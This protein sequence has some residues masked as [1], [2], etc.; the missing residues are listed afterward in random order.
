MKAKVDKPTWDAIKTEYLAN[1][2]SYR[3]IGK[4]YGVDYTAICRKAKRE[5]WDELRDVIQRDVDERMRNA[6][7]DTKV[8]NTQRAIDMT[9]AL[10]VKLENAI[11][12]VGKT[13]VSAMRSIV[14][15]MKDLNEMGVFAVHNED[16]ADIRVELQG[17]DDYAD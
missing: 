3:A 12:L 9:N 15:S 7:V 8:S 11:S 13:N 5:H 6:V 10:M 4:K 17:A 2:L 14:S 16:S 1:V